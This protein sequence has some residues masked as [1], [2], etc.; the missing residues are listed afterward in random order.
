MSDHTNVRLETTSGT[1]VAYLAPNFEMTPALANSLFSQA[2]GRGDPQIVRDRRQITN[3]L[4]AQGEFMHSENLP[5]AH[6]TDLENLIGSSPVTAMDQINRVVE[7][8][9]RGG[10]FHLYHKGNE[11][12]ATTASGVDY[13]NGVYPAV[14]IDT[15]R[16][17]TRGGFDR[18]EYTLKFQVGVTRR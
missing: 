11:Y 14:N 13:Q 1:V 6:R 5:D 3:E 18:G 15:F 10:P 16:P 12:T 17:P 8:M 9:F 4:T 2:P 7:F